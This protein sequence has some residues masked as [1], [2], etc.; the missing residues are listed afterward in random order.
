MLNPGHT[1][2]RKTQSRTC[3]IQ[4]CRQSATL[5][6]IPNVLLPVQPRALIGATV[7][8]INMIDRT[9][10]SHFHAQFSIFGSNTLDIARLYESLKSWREL[11]AGWMHA[12]VSRGHFPSKVSQN[13]CCC[14]LKY[15]RLQLGRLIGAGSFTFACV[16]RRHR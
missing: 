5:W 11:L 2:W 8:S 9:T 13:F 16:S 12:G 14:S 10:N 15:S 4:P 1:Q 7:Q 6:D 3:S